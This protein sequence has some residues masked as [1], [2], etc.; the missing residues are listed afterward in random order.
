MDE[1]TRNE[2]TGTSEIDPIRPEGLDL[3]FFRVEVYLIPHCWMEVA[4]EPFVPGD[5]IID[6]IF[7]VMPE[8]LFKEREIYQAT[9]DL[10]AALLKDH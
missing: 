6:P 3:E 10:V 5:K 2:K 1:F 9:E 7:Q 8:I 4:H